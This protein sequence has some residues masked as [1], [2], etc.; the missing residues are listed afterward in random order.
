MKEHKYARKNWRTDPDF[1]RH[2]FSFFKHARAS[3]HVFLGSVCYWA[4]GAAKAPPA[5]KS[6]DALCDLR[7]L[8]LLL[9]TLRVLCKC[10]ISHIFWEAGLLFSRLKFFVARAP[11]ARG[12]RFTEPPE[13]ACSAPTDT[14]VRGR[15]DTGEL[16]LPAWREPGQGRRAN[17]VGRAV[18]DQGRVFQ[19]VCCR[20]QTLRNSDV[21]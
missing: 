1:P 10:V 21:T 17:A 8:L 5:A 16:L 20:H 7:W 12:P 6:C 13:P 3:R 2:G 9:E 18:S 4:W 15:S 11:G 14:V 19:H